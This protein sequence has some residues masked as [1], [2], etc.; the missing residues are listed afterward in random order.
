MRL[1]ANKNTARSA[2]LLYLIVVIAS[3]FSLGYVPSKLIVWGDA[4][5]TFQQIAAS[6]TL[7]RLS[8]LS[9][10]ICYVAFLILPLVL[11]K[12]LNSVNQMAAKLMVVLSVISVPISMLNLQNQY[13]ALA[14]INTGFPNIESQLMLLLERYDSGI[15]LVSVFWGLWLLPFGRLVYKSG[16]CQE[17]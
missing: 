4:A 15:L 12:L 9:S 1:G 10:V 5:K 11:Y 8:I 13:A 2:G 7:F 6:E 3:I 16:F 17:F 14:L